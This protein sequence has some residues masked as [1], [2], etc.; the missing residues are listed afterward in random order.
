MAL[1]SPLCALLLATCTSAK[2]SPPLF[3][4]LD[5]GKPDLLNHWH[6]EASKAAKSGDVASVKGT[7]AKS[8]DVNI[9]SR[10]LDK[11][12]RNDSHDFF[13]MALNVPLVQRQH[14]E[15]AQHPAS[16][17]SGAHQ[18]TAAD[19]AENPRGWTR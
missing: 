10:Y 6:T 16:A 13:G 2:T 8:W 19:A 3:V 17:S 12:M 11:G 15:K 5:V 9:G 4:Q 7:T 18:I 14:P 1:F